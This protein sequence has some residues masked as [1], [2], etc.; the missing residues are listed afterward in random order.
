MADVLMIEISIGLVELKCNRKV[1]DQWYGDLM[2]YGSFQML[3][4]ALLDS[5]LHTPSMRLLLKERWRVHF[6]SFVTLPDRSGQ[7]LLLIIKTV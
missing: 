4:A 2:L 7:L 3:Y 1:K 6:R 5:G